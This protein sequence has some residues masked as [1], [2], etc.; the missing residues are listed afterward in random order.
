MKKEWDKME[1]NIKEAVKDTVMERDKKK[2]RRRG[3]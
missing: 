3:W 2:E 1:R